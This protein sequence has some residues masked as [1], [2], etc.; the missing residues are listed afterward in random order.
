MSNAG[1]PGMLSVTWREPEEI[2][3]LLRRIRELTDRPFGVNLMLA[4]NMRKRLAGGE[5]LRQR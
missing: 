4:W 2:R 3:P 1:A 5:A